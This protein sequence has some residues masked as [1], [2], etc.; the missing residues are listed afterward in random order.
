MILKG[1][2]QG[3]FQKRVIKRFIGLI[4]KEVEEL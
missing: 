4:P 1:I 2:E 3:A